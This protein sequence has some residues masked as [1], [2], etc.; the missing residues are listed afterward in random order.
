MQLLIVN[1]AKLLIIGFW[2]PRHVLYSPSLCDVVFALEYGVV[3][4]W[5]Y[6]GEYPLVCVYVCE[7]ERESNVSL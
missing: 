1:H 7:K 2:L 6:V 3:F 5:V 4:L